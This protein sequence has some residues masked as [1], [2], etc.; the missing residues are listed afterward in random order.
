[1]SKI[2]EQLLTSGQFQNICD[3]SAISGQ[4]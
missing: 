3:I 4:L 1:M 2:S